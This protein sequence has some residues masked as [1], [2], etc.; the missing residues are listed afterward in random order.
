MFRREW[1]IK[2]RM[3]T[4]ITV[5]L[6]VIWVVP[7]SALASTSTEVIA[8]TTATSTHVAVGF[9]EPFS[10]EQYGVSAAYAMTPK[11][12]RE[13]YA[14]NADVSWPLASLTKLVSASVWQTRT[15]PWKRVMSIRAEDEVGGGRLRVPVG[16][17][18]RFED[19]WY[20][21]ITASANNAAMMLARA[22]GV[23]S[24]QLVRLMQQE[25]KRAGA[26]SAVFAEPSGM[27]EK[28]VANA[29][30][31]AL[32]ADRA[33]AFRPLQKAAS[34][35][36]YVVRVLNGKPK[37]RTIHTTNQ[38]LSHDPDVWV[39]GGKTGYLEESRYNFVAWMRPL[40]VDGKPKTGK[41]VL[42]VIFGAPTKE[43]SFAAAKHLA[44]SLWQTHEFTTSTGASPGA[45]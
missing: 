2:E 38:L 43:Q 8:E 16:T 3:I 1:G 13:L 28:N 27:S 25:A 10:P 26:G 7:C 22:L 21:S 39:I 5:L 29:K 42:V 19:L 20:A 36:K 33:F 4:R 6:F 37:E 18:I 23:S 35:E 34:T 31:M 40:G 32:L 24:T 30:D 14:W 17:K 9:V 11:T 15:V 44:Q 45:K 41:D 12:H